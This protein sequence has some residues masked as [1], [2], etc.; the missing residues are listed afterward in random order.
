[1][2]IS[3]ATTTTQTHG[4]ELSTDW[5]ALDWMRLEG[6]FTYTRLNTPPWDSI[7]SDTAGLTP[8]TQGTLRCLMDLTEK[9]KLNLSLRHIGNLPT[10]NAALPAPTSY[11]PAYTA[12]DANM[13]Y[14]PHKGLELSL[15]GQ[16]LFGQHLEYINNSL[17]NIQSQIPRSVFAKVTWSH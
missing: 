7:N 15:V 2:I 8:R 4:L 3:N 1:M 17:P 13:S 5:R 16:N 11:V 10:H 6:T 14:T 12:A 9:T